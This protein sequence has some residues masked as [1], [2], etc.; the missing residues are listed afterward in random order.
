MTR[1]E[2]LQERYEDA[3]LA[4]LMDEAAVSEGETALLENERLQSDPDAAVPEEVR[5]RCLRTIHRHFAVQSTRRKGQTAL[6]YLKR[7]AVAALVGAVLFTVA[8][9]AS[10]T[11]RVNTLNLIVEVFDD[12]T[13]FYFI[14]DHP[15][16]STQKA[17]ATW[18]PEG[19]ILVDE[20]SDDLGNW[21]I[22]NT[23]TGETLQIA[24]TIGAGTTLNIDTEN[25]ETKKI[26]INGAEALLVQ[27]ETD[28]QIVWATSDKTAF[29][30]VIGTGTSIS[31]LIQIANEVT[32]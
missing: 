13:D 9:A 20:G 3:L 7:V 17:T 23:S 24:Y 32:Y 11:F 25:A 12:S 15:T 8:F 16:G 27:K 21:C 5:A 10:E 31:D 6:K 26:N 28:T 18:L 14:G 2:E 19:Y 1:R 30:Q 29:L 4:L 22:Y